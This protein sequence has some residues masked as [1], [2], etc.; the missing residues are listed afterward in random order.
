MNKAGVFFLGALTGIVVL[1]GGVALTLAIVP[2]GTYVNGFGTQ[3]V[4]ENIAK[5]GLFDAIN[6]V[7][8]YTIDDVPVIKTALDRIFTPEGM[9]KYVSLDYEAI[10]TVTLTDP[11]LGEKLSA[12]IKIVATL[13]SLDVNLGDFGKL[14]MFKSWRQASPSADDITK[15]PTVFYFKDA[16]GNYLH[17]YDAQGQK[18]NGYTEGQLYLPNLSQVVVT[19]LF[20][21]LSFQIQDLTYG[22]LAIQ[23]L[24][25]KPSELENNTIYR[26][27]KDTK[28]KDLTTLDAGEFLLKEVLKPADNQKLYDVLVDALGKTADE[29]K[30]KDLSGL[31]FDAVHLEKF[32]PVTSAGDLAKVLVDMTGK[33][34]YAEVTVADLKSA[35]MGKIKFSHVLSNAGGNT[36]LEALLKDDTVTV[37]GLG[38]AIN[39]LSLYDVYGKDVFVT[40][41]GGR[42]N[43][44]KYA[45]DP[46]TG[47]LTY[48]TSLP[49]NG[50]NTYYVS[51][52]AGVWLLLSYDA[53]NIDPSNGR[54]RTFKPGTLTLSKLQSDSTMLSTR[55][56]EARIYQ[57]ISAGVLD[58]TGYPDLVKAKT[59]SEALNPIP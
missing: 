5:R 48:D 19:D 54:A 18:I 17:A 27:I 40:G 47:I 9:G 25:G 1:G 31:S 32:L 26:L 35:D 34:S 53:E 42:A 59:L 10:K 13:T 22:E 57:L 41:A 7:N 36:I 23:F 38:D 37:S 49:D 43:E 24:G 3:V 8:E 14:D 33:A 21:G 28:L 15:H 55:V 30:I 51:A 50:E 4:G 39:G 44:D 45:L 58:G 20:E 52:K 56:G 46:A 29:I 11:K 2:T 12:G 6:H 16:S